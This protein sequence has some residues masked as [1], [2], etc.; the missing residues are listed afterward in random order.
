MPDEP[1]QPGNR[2]FY[3]R[4]KSDQW[5]DE[6]RQA[7][8]DTVFSLREGEAGLSV[9]DTAE[10]S[11]RAVLEYLLQEWDAIALKSE[12]DARWAAKQRAIHG[13][14][15]EG[16]LESGWGVAE[17]SEALFLRSGFQ[18]SPYTERN[19]HLEILGMKEAF[20][21]KSLDIIDDPEC[22]ILSVEECLA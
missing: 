20:E 9:F 6:T 14:T 2:R 18:P 1:V 12:R 19:G 4:I 11:P 7:L 8:Q 3:R 17:V 21:E 22:R 10:A 5:Q 13:E 15:V 16:L